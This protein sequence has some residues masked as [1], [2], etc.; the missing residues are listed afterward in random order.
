MK[1]YCLLLAIILVLF[2]CDNNYQTSRNSADQKENVVQQEIKLTPQEILA[3]STVALSFSGIGLNDVFGSTINKAKKDK[4]IY[5]VKITECNYGKGKK[6]SFSTDVYFADEKYPDKIYVD[7]FSF[8]D[9]IYSISFSTFIYDKYDKLNTLYF[10][11]YNKKYCIYKED[12]PEWGEY[13]ADRNHDFYYT[14]KFRNQT[15]EIV[16]KCTEH[17]E[18]YVK[19]PT[20]SYAPNRYGVRYTLSFEEF[21]VLYKDNVRYIDAWYHDYMIQDSLAKIKRYNDSIEKVK[22]KQRAENQDI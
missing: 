18:N 22:Q 10:D 19:D 13:N 14:W 12:Y 20:K 15:L 5:D 4:K 7:V 1:K 6:A 8:K 3:D 16:E 17:R 21:S 11:R 9:T 2:G